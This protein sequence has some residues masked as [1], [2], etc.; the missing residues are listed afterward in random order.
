L[1]RQTRIVGT[2][3]AH[4]AVAS[5]G[6]VTVVEIS[7][8]HPILTQSVEDGVKKWRFVPGREGSFDL[9]CDF[10]LD[11]DSV[12]LLRRSPSVVQPL[13]IRIV[14]G[15]PIVDTIQATAQKHK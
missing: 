12:G 6:S 13:H 1:A 7:R 3:I 8:G 11:F 14:A 2:V 5:D 15:A 10:A 9:T 4:V